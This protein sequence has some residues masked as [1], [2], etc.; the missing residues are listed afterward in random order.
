[1]RLHHLSDTKRGVNCLNQ[2]EAL[3]QI[4]GIISLI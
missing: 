4:K 3:P 2:K 1:M